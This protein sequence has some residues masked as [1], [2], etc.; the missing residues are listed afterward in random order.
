MNGALELREDVATRDGPAIGVFAAGDP[1]IDEDTCGN[2]GPKPGVVFAHAINEALAQSG[3]GLRRGCRP[4]RSSP[5][6]SPGSPR[7]RRSAGDGC[8]YQFV[9]FLG[10]WTGRSSVR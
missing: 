4:C 8:R 3:R 6:R 1:R 10:S 7:L 5:G 9:T 2:S